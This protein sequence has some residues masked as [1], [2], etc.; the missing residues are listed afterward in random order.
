MPIYYLLYSLIIFVY[1]TFHLLYCEVKK[2]FRFF[3]T[4]ICSSIARTGRPECIPATLEGDTRPNLA[5]DCF[6]QITSI[7]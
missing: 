3:S 6:F 4:P 1:F 2:I 7:N 5:F